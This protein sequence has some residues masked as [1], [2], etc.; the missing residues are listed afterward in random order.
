MRAAHVL[1]QS[2]P[3]GAESGWRSRRFASLAARLRAPLLDRQLAAGVPSWRSAQHASRALQLTNARRRR[4]LGASL[5]RLTER[6]ERP[7][8]PLSSA[9][10]PPCREQVR[11]ALPEIMAMSAILRSAEPIDARGVAKLRALLSDG[12]GPCYKRSC[13]SALTD[14]LQEVSRWLGVTG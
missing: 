10:I 12:S 7:L 11:D 14:A 6:A 3:A 13:P 9:A 5:E 8:A 2:A 4:T 1:G